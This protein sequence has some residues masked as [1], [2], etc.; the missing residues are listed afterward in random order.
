MLVVGFGVGFGLMYSYI[1]PK[2]ADIV[3]PIP[4]FVPQ[5]AAA[6]AP[7]IDARVVREL[8]ETLKR[9]P[10]NFAA[11]RELGNIRYDMR[12]FTDSAALYARAL[13]VQP[14]DINLRSDRGSA[15]LLG[16]QIDDAIG[17]LKIVLSKDPT[18]PQALYI[19]GMA[20]LEGKNDREGALSS[21]RKLVET[22]PDL[23]E[24]NV[25]K[26]QIKQIEELTGQR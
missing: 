14:N 17:E 20:L 10:K 18:H 15:L 8:E 3:K 23:P 16:N 13:E 22:H 2:A 5:R 21:L 19:Y 4:P 6:P 26:Q 7:R 25:I 9:D 12:D 1:S 11:L 24:L